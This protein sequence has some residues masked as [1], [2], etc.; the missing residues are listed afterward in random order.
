ML[1]QLHFVCF[2]Q[3][4]VVALLQELLGLLIT[5]GPMFPKCV[6]HVCVLS[7]FSRVQLFVTPWT[8][9]HQTP[10]SMGFSRQEYQSGL[11]SPPPG[12]LPDPGIQPE[13]PEAPA[14]QADFFKPLSHRGSP[15]VCV[16][17]F[18]LLGCV[19][20]CDPMDCS[21]PGF[22]APGT[23]QTRILEWVAISFSRHPSHTGHQGL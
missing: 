13:P 10:L 4:V 17:V 6:L 8:V 12:E 14:L 5:N 2:H 15:I 19:Q 11:P 9:D 3:L 7:C 23:L 1:L 18:Q 20:L 22:S 16:C 21:L